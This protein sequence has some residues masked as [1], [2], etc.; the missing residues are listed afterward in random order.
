MKVGSQQTVRRVGP[1]GLA[2]AL[3]A[4]CV[5]LARAGTPRIEL[6]EPFET[7]QVLIHFYTEASRSYTVQ[8][9]TSFIQSN[10]SVTAVWSNI[11]FVPAQPFD[12]H[13]IAVDTNKTLPVRFYRLKVV[14]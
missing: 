13:F 14:P 10:N 4:L 5:A 8:R 9:C 1:A 7:N 11:A 6:V 12:D 3:I 2:M